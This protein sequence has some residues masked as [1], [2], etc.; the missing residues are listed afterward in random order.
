M[1]VGDNEIFI[2]GDGGR[3][4]EGTKGATIVHIFQQNRFFCGIR[5][6]SKNVRTVCTRSGS[7]FILILCIY[8]KKMWLEILVLVSYIYYLPK[9][10]ETI[11]WAGI[12]SQS[13]LRKMYV[14]SIVLSAVF[15][16]C[17][18]YKPPT[19]VSSLTLFYQKLF[20][21]SAALWAPSMYYFPQ[22]RFLTIIVLTMTSASAFMMAMTSPWFIYIF[23]HCFFMDN[24]LWSYMYLKLRDAL[25]A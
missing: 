17:F 14:V 6:D 19:P 10:H 22:H 5:F 25:N 21:I 1:G 2:A 13:P 23:L 18:M 12:P 11:S 7:M 20:L 16:V 24:L 3:E 9:I 15:Y 8:K 4:D